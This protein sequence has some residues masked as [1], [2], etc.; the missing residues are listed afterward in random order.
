M[1]LSLIIR[2]EKKS[3]QENAKICSIV[4]LLQSSKKNKC[5]SKSA[6]KVFEA[7]F[8]MKIFFINKTCMQDQRISKLDT[9]D[10]K[11]KYSYQS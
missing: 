2:K 11:F 7:H 9:D 3:N 8:F 1:V 4:L 10:N 6:A 5:F